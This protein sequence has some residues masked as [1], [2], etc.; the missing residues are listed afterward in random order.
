MLDRTKKG[1]NQGVC[2]AI[3]VI[4]RTVVIAI[5]GTEVA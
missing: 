5:P 4:T 3:M 1:Y 2:A